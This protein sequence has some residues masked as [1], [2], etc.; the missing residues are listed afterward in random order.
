MLKR[1][2]LEEENIAKTEQEHLGRVDV[3]TGNVV[4]QLLS[5]DS[6]MAEWGRL[7]EECP[8]ATVFQHSTFVKS[9]YI[10][11]SRQHIPILVISR[12]KGRLTGLLP[13]A[14]GVKGLG[15]AGAGGWDAYYHTWLTRPCHGDTFITAALQALHRC[16]P[17]QDI[18]FKYLPP[19]APRLWFEA[20]P[21]WRKKCVVRTFDR[22]LL[23]LNDSMTD[24]LLHKKAFKEQRN[25]LQRLGEL[26][27]KFIDDLETFTNTLNVLA[28]H[29]DFRKAA[30]LNLMPFREDPA[31]KAFLLDQ[32]KNGLLIV[33]TLTVDGEII[34]GLVATKG[35]RNWV[36]GAGI[37]THAPAFSKYS[38]GYVLLQM[39]GYKLKQEGFDYF[40]LTPGGHNYKD[41]HANTH[42]QVFELRVTSTVKASC[43]KDFYTYKEVVKKK[44]AAKGI[45]PRLLSL[46][47]QTKISMAL[48]KV[49]A[50]EGLHFLRHFKF[51]PSKETG[52]RVYKLTVP[53]G[54]AP[55]SVTVRRN[56][57]GDLLCYSASGTGQSR[58]DFTN[59]AMKYYENRLMPYSYCKEG[60]LLCLVWASHNGVVPR[61]SEKEIKSVVIPT[62]S[63][64][65]KHLY[66]HPEAAT[67]LKEFLLTV[68]TELL[69]K[70]EC[71]AVYLQEAEFTS[72]L[73]KEAQ[74]LEEVR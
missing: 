61:L 10:S 70:A 5:D 33:T 41:R 30:T 4:V 28:D 51:N 14:E 39:F 54:F 56:N 22:P 73:L 47:V 8:W 45:N 60:K 48:A 37:N 53:K 19:K 59:A 27:L 34:A 17:G 16:F 12:Y 66:C 67:K 26:Q 31:K 20:D 62:G 50:T 29:Y 11:Y 42:D 38:P 63:I 74:V 24:K 35:N 13:L 32:F 40:D 6:F 49:R 9:W 55:A 68:A 52:L 36:H 1:D 2:T 64:C 23:D 71:N 21:K 3:L 69:S 43:L 15:M 72:T 65:L 46:T 7:Y 58:W 18:F 57:P 44:L 25:R